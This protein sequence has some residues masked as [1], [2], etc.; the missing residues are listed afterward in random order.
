MSLDKAIDHGK[1]HRNPYRG[2]KAS[3][4]T[5]RNHGSCEVCKGNRLYSTRKRAESL[6]FR[7]EEDAP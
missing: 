4:C 1:E 6:K 2:A 3:D 5:C 7:E